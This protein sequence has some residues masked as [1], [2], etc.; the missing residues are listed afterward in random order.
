MGIPILR[1]MKNVSSGLGPKSVSRLESGYFPGKGRAKIYK[2]RRGF[3][4]NRVFIIVLEHSSYM[5]K[6]DNARTILLV[7]IQNLYYKII[8]RHFK[9]DHG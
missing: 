2:R 8:C 4:N 6:I 1:S 9:Q 5:S 3:E 7:Y